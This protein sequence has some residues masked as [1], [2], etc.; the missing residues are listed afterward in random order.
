MYIPFGKKYGDMY[1]RG[2][3]S[4]MTINGSIPVSFIYSELDKLLNY[5]ARSVVC[6]RPV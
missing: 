1:D 3:F 2:F 5:E 6:D 4:K